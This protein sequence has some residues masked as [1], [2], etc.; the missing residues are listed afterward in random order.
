MV[1]RRIV[2]VS[3]NSRLKGRRSPVGYGRRTWGGGRG[4]GTVIRET[5]GLISIFSEKWGV[6][7]SLYPVILLGLVLDCIACPHRHYR[8]GKWNPT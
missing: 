3:L 4:R 5:F 7:G 2:Q 8:F 6:F 1:S